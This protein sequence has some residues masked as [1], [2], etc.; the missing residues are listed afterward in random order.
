MRTKIVLLCAAAIVSATTVLIGCGSSSSPQTGFVN[1]SI[2]DPA[3]CSAPNGPFAHIYVTVTDVKIHASSS[4]GPNDPGWIDLTPDLKNNGPK[5]VDLLN[6]PANECFLASL[7]ANTE[8]QAGNYQQIRIMLATDASGLPSNGNACK[9]LPGNVGNCVQMDDGTLHPLLLSSEANTGIKIPSGQIAGGQ[10]TVGAGKTEDLDI[11]FNSCASIVVQGNGQYRLKP[12]LTA[13]E[14]GTNPSINGTLV[15]SV[16]KQPIPNAI[17]VV[18]LERRDSNGNDHVVMSTLAD[19][20]NGSFALCP[21]PGG[22][23]DLVAAAKDGNGNLYAATVVTGVTDGSAVGTIQLFKT[24]VAA[25]SLTGNVTT[26][27]MADD[28]ILAALQTIGNGVQ[29]VT[30]LADQSMATAPLST[31]LAN[32]GT[33]CASFTLSVPAAPPQVAAF[34]PGTPISGYAPAPTPNGI[35]YL[36][37]GEPALLP[38]GTPDCTPADIYTSLVA[39]TPGNASG[40]GTLQFTGCQ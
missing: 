38:D 5:Q 39:V 21:V 2:S 14:V 4:A 8:L 40:V 35:R 11:D 15:D 32:C 18:A 16:T 23:Y 1:T 24:G 37:N 31:S 28:V 30:P 27:P 20:A 26:S 7:G 10:F 36:V 19:P 13:G 22:T 25:A 34:T 9:Q 12:V 17:A 3:P 6:E 29:V 33:L